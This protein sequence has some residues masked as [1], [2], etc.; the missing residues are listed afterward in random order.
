MLHCIILIALG[1]VMWKFLPG[2]ITA[3]SKKARSY[4]DLGLQ[5]LGIILMITGAIQLVRSIYN[6][7]VP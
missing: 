6:L 4:I 5:I 3:A 1:F 7:I 2:K